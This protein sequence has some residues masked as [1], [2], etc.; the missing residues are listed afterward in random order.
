MESDLCVR[1]GLVVG[2]ALA[3]AALHATGCPPRET[4]IDVTPAGASTLINACGRPPLDVTTLCNGLSDT[5]AGAGAQFAEACRAAEA[6]CRKLEA[7]Q[8]A[9]ICVAPELP[10]RTAD[11]ASSA[12]VMATRVVLM[13][14]GDADAPIARAASGC[15]A[16]TFACEG[17]T[18][19]DRCAAEALNRGIASAIPE[20]GLGFDGLEEAGDAVPV[21]LVYF[22]FDRDGAVACTT[23][24]LFACGALAQRVAGADTY[25]L[26]CASCQA[27]AAATVETAPC[28]TD[29]FLKTCAE[30]SSLVD[31]DDTG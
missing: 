19:D 2:F 28:V 14:P 6:E 24:E 29:C 25:D 4:R 10:Q 27:G 5:C 3:A 23:N 26:V 12:S 22:D 11:I 16:I 1:P 15:G 7:E 18:L 21:V 9:T 20:D 8:A 30:L 17:A 13:A 31:A